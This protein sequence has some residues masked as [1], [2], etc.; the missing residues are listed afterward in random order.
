MALKHIASESYHASTTF[1]VISDVEE[2]SVV[3]RSM[4][5]TVAVVA[6]SLETFVEEIFGTLF[7]EKTRK[8]MVF[9]DVELK[10]RSNGCE[11]VKWEWLLERGS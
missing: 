10:A 4:M 8:G 2:A 11:N 1:S 3:L 7:K 9:K 6:G 5:G